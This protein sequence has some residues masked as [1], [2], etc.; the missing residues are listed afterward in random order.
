MGLSLYVPIMVLG[1]AG[2]GVR[3]LLLVA[4]AVAGPKRW[5]RAKLEA[6]ECGIEPTPAAAAPGSR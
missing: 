5:N 2:R 6:Y 3:R 1:G 4:G